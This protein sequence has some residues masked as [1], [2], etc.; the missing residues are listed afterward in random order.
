MMRDYLYLNRYPQLA[1][2][3]LIIDVVKHV[4]EKVL[5]IA[6]IVGSVKDQNK[7]QVLKGYKAAVVNSINCCRQPQ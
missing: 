4:T 1:L 3:K 6:V 5:M 2:L 7:Y